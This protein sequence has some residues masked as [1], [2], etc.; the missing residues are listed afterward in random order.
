MLSLVRALVGS[1][2]VAASPSKA[3]NSPPTT[4]PPCVTYWAGRG[5]AEPL[6]CILAVAGVE[7]TNVFLEKKADIEKLRSEKK[8]AFD[9]VPLVE[10]DGLNL[11]Q[12]FPTALYLAE[13]Y[14]LLPAE[15]KDR[16]KVGSIV[17]ATHDA[18]S[19][20]VSFPFHGKKDKLMEDVQ[21]KKGLFGRYCGKWEEQLSETDGPYFFDSPTLADVSVFEVMDFFRHV[22]GE[23]A[24]RKSFQTFPRLLAL[25]DAVL[26]LGRLKTWRDIERPKLFIKDWS[27]Y[28]QVV[29]RTLY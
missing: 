4:A 2:M 26:N 22:F 17:A 24:M 9:Q 12:T 14:G 11:V 10:I 28:G 8:L 3:P 13:T 25:H 7:F 16:Y 18:R 15:P 20:F 21:D 27:E 19:P 23:D 5:K 6:R 1:C 29:I